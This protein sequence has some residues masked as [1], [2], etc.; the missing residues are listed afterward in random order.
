MRNAS[1]NQT[2]THLYQAFTSLQ[3][4]PFLIRPRFRS[5]TYLSR[6]ACPRQATYSDSLRAA[7]PPGEGIMG[8]EIYAQINDHL[9]A[10]RIPK[11]PLCKGGCQ[12]N[13]LTGGLTIPPSQLTLCH[14]PLH[15]GGLGA[16]A[17]EQPSSHKRSF[18]SNT[19]VIARE[20]SDRGTAPAGASKRA[21]AKGGS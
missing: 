13:S 12:A 5:A 6:S 7:P 16:A 9:S 14:L 19:T 21:T 18:M 2:V 1:G 17:P 20:Q 10:Q 8:A 3:I 11:A 4:S 15:K